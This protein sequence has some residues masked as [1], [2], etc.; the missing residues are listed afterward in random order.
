MNGVMRRRVLLRLYVACRVLTW[1]T[2][3]AA[4]RASGEFVSSSYRF[5]D[6]VDA[7][8]FIN[9]DTDH[10]P[11]E[12]LRRRGARACGSVVDPMIAANA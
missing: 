1:I 3:S 8:M 7:V 2:V 5:P 12:I 4:A 10:A 6:D 9:S 11:E